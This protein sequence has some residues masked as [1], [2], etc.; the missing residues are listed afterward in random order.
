MFSFRGLRPTGSPLPYASADTTRSLPFLA[1]LLAVQ[2]ARLAEET[3]KT[4]DLV[5][6]SEGT[7]V[8][9]EYLAA[10]RA[11]PLHV[12]VLAS[13]LPRP[14]RDCIPPAG[15]AG[16][17]FA[18]SMEIQAILDIS[19]AEAPTLDIGVDMAMVR[20]LLAQGPLFR[21]RMLCPVGWTR[22]VALLPLSTVIADPPRTGRGHPGGRRTCT[23]R[24][25]GADSG[26][27]SR[28]RGRLHG[29]T[30]LPLF[31]VGHRVP[32]LA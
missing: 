7:F 5:A 11:P 3:G 29:T 24:H 6:V 27:P 8:V 20:S 13:P 23:P 14:D 10:H 28:H 2:V 26:D 17:G 18:A 4:V 15:R 21:Q 9:R 32:A 25:P 12:L 19:R 16:Y 1:R 22:I 31:R 30:G